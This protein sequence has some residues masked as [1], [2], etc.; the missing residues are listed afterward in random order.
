MSPDF[1]KTQGGLGIASVPVHQKTREGRDAMHSLPFDTSPQFPSQ[2]DLNTDR[3]RVV[4]DGSSNKIASV[5]VTVKLAVDF[6]ST[7]GKVGSQLREVFVK[8]LQ[9]DLARASGWDVG[10]SQG[11]APENFRVKMVAPGSVI[12]DVDIL[13][14][15]SGGSADPWLVATTLY[16]QQSDPNSALLSGI[17]TKHLTSLSVNQSTDRQWTDQ[18]KFPSKFSRKSPSN[19]GDK[20]QDA[21]SKNEARVALP[22]AG[23]TE[24]DLASARLEYLEV[25]PDMATTV[26]GDW[27][28]G[29]ESMSASLS[30]PVT[31]NE[32]MT[33]MGDFSANS[34]WEMSPSWT[35]HH[36]PRPPTP[37][38]GRP[39]TPPRGRLSLSA[40]PNVLRRSMTPESDYSVDKNSSQNSSYT[41]QG[42]SIVMSAEMVY[43]D[44]DSGVVPA[45]EGKDSK[46]ITFTSSNDRKASAIQTSRESSSNPSASSKKGHSLTEHADNFNPVT[47]MGDWDFMAGMSDDLDLSGMSP[48]SLGQPPLRA[49]PDL[50]KSKAMDGQ[51]PPRKPLPGISISQT[52]LKTGANPVGRDGALT[53]N[54]GPGMMDA[55]AHRLMTFRINTEAAATMRGVNT[56]LAVLQ[57]RN[58]AADAKIR[59]QENLIAQRG[60]S[61]RNLAVGA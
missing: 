46:R 13:E 23:R 29:G 48:S 55:D 58:D 17:L 28:D 47:V 53:V 1:T 22:A 56:L 45:H 11:A 52:D 20:Q 6:Q 57:A 60:E 19:S 37:P 36:H 49:L 2:R 59:S 8:D 16:W 25:K 7:A 43:F 42:E 54:G 31:Q 30:S 27:T 33:T 3:R 24:Q 14:Q 12:T 61:I 10:L 21:N 41:P 50:P 18:T 15:S 32:P 51:F 44:E 34:S 4:P 26:M 35:E 9:H 5:S 40:S 39:P 38:K